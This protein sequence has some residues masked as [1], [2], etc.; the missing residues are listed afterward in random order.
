[1]TQTP[2]TWMMLPEALEQYRAAREAITTKGSTFGQVLNLQ[3]NEQPE[4]HGTV[5]VVPIAGTLVPHRSEYSIALNEC[6]QDSIRRMIQCAAADEDVKT[7]VLAINSP[8]GLVSGTAETADLIAEVAHKK[9]V[10]ACVESV[11]ASGAYYLASQADH[12]VA[13][14]DDKIGSIGVLLSMVDESEAYR[15]Q[16]YRRVVVSS[17]PHKGTF[18]PGRNVTDADLAPVQEMVDEIAD[19]FKAAVSRGRGLYGNALHAV[20]DG[21]AFT[22]TRALS[23]RL[24][25]GI[26]FLDHIVAELQN[27]RGGQSMALQSNKPATL[28]ELKQACP[29]ADADFLV[30]QAEAGATVADAQKAWIDRQNAEITSLRRSKSAPHSSAFDQSVS[31]PYGRRI[32]D[33]DEDDDEGRQRRRTFAA[34]PFSELVACKIDDGLTRSDAIRAAAIEQPEL[35]RDY[36]L[37]QNRRSV[38]H[39]IQSR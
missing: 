23:L 16:G 21:R 39:L 13:G 17:G 29:G 25:D 9:T 34:D 36:L 12:I 15:K 26:G 35:H 24:I 4:I 11:C 30:A 19:N 33:G 38:H 14:R 3:P 7:I 31:V 32:E 1:M 6:P 2:S 27:N 37:S 18:V 28:A 5:A 8:G 10:V 22:A 20:A